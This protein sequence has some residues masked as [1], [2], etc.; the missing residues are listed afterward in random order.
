MSVSAPYKHQMEGARLLAE[1]DAFALLCEMGTG[2]SRMLCMDIQ[3]KIE[4]GEIDRVVIVA[5]SGSYRNWN[6]ELERWLPKEFYD[7]L[8]IFTWV[9][10]KS[11]VKKDFKEFLAFKGSKPRILLI[12]VEALS[13]VDAAKDGLVEFL[14]GGNAMFAID[15]SQCVKS[16]DSLRTKFILKT[17]G[18]A[19]Y[20]RILTGL[21]APENPLNTW[22]Q[23]YFLDPNILG[24]KSFFSFRARY[25]ITRK[26]DFKQGGRPIDVVVGYRHVEELQQKI[27]RKSFRVQTEDV[28]DLPEK[29][30]MPIRDV[31]L[32]MEQLKAYNDIKRLAMTEINGQYVTAQ[33]AAAVLTKLHSVLCGHVVDENGNL[34]DVPSHRVEAIQEVLAD[35]QGKAI[36]WAPYP[37]LLTKIAEA[38]EAEYGAE[39]TVRYWGET[40]SD[41]RVAGVKRFQEDPKCRFFVSN[42]SVGGEGITLT[43]A[44]L[45]IYAAN[46][47]KASDR[48]QSEARAHRAGQTRPVVYVDIASKGSMEEK[49]INALRNKFDL[50]AL[51]TGDK[52]KEWLV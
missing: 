49:L 34:H 51:V 15:E 21:V 42:P 3:Y 44:T 22:S 43:A 24:H 38:L 31:R 46:S 16:P 41:D 8:K 4:R 37:R 12:N 2:K 1:H 29:I 9:S 23:F 52:L 13:R 25:A 36:I 27:L 7:S 39:S 40:S 17:G 33:I 45:V 10:S 20:R 35:H 14:S 30:Y 48:Q 11:S 47:W 26:V 19:K 5:P 6:G 18:L 32:S 50:A 28:L